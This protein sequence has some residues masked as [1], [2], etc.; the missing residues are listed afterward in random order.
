MQT[1]TTKYHGPTDYKGARL[2]ATTTSG[3]KRWFSWEYDINAHENHQRAARALA[4]ELKWGGQWVSG[5]L[6]GGAVVWVPVFHGE[7]VTFD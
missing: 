7:P 6:A 2:S 3:I 4:L 1:I 5:T